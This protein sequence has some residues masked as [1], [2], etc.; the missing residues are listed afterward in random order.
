[1][2]LSFKIFRIGVTFCK[3][4]NCLYVIKSVTSLYVTCDGRKYLAYF[5]TVIPPYFVIVIPP[6]FVLVIPPYFPIV[7]P[8]YTVIVIPL[9]FVN[10][11]PKYLVL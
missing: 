10:V 2:K 1:M 5:D 9:Y 7:I 4:M 3:E 8:P 11:I 6:Y